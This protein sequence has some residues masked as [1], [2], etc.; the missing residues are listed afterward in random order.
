MAPDIRFFQAAATAIPTLLIAVAVSARVFE[1]NIPKLPDGV[2][3]VAMITGLIYI[4]GGEVTCLRV[5]ARGRPKGHDYNNVWISIGL[6]LALIVVQPLVNQYLS[7]SD[8]SNKK[9]I[10][11]GI[12]I[13][14]MIVVA[15]VIYG[16]V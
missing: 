4:V 5:L 11:Q 3:I 12:W 15:V 13:I 2:R 10:L 8:Y 14:A 6:S 7:L 9:R 16:V 1:T